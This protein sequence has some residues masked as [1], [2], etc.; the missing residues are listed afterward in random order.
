MVHKLQCAKLNTPTSIQSNTKTYC[1]TSL[2][3]HETKDV[4]HA[5]LNFHTTQLKGSGSLKLS[6]L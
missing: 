2:E 1:A 5:V 4:V 6:V 3:K